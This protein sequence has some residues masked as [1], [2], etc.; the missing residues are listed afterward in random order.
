MF[1]IEKLTKL[2]DIERRANPST[3]VLERREVEVRPQLS[4]GHIPASC[5]K[6]IREQTPNS[7][8][9]VGA[10]FLC[11]R[12]SCCIAQAGLDTRVVWGLF[13]Y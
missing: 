1:L 9:G 6:C 5:D 4:W 10:L 8:M 11:N 13:K 12:L 3:L 2:Q 7:G